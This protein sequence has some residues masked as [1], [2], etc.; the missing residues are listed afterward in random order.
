MRDSRECRDDKKIRLI[1][2][3]A[4]KLSVR[5]LM[6]P[7]ATRRATAHPTLLIREPAL[8]ASCGPTLRSARRNAPS[9][10]VA[11]KRRAVMVTPS[12]GDHIIELV[13][14]IS[15]RKP[16]AAGF[17]LQR[18]SLVPLAIAEPRPGSLNHSFIAAAIRATCRGRNGPEVKDRSFHRSVCLSR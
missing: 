7:T 10:R 5:N 12:L 9:V 1:R 8:I 17:A 11:S 15:L 4:T 13:A 3:R 16:R 2:R 6:P 18:Q 14:I